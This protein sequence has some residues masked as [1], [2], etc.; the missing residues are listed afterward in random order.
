MS[1]GRN[2][3]EM[4][5]VVTKGAQS[6]EPMQKLTTGI[7]DGQSGSWEDLGGPTPQ[8]YKADDDS[9]KLN[10]PGKTLAQVKNVVNKGAKSADPMGKLASGAVKQAEDF[11]YE[12]DLVEESDEE[13]DDEEEDDEEDE[14]GAK[15]KKK[16][17]AE[18]KKSEE[19]DEEEDE[20]GRAHV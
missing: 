10:V 14:S 2:L 5:N 20:I 7:P 11:E 9:A 19:D 15:S 1:V 6:A 4:E 3:Q 12:E 16:K 13:E 17:V 8:N 18:A